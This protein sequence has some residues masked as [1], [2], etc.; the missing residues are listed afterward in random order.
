MSV[1]YKTNIIIMYFNANLHFPFFKKAISFFDMIC[2]D[3]ENKIIFPYSKFIE[4]EI[5]V[6]FINDISLLWQ[7]EYQ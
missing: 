7:D 2:Q 6:R 1:I 5:H 3:L 4:L